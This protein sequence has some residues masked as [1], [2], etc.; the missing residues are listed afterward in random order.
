MGFTTTVFEN[1][2]RYYK[3]ISSFCIQNKLQQFRSF[4]L[5]SWFLNIFHKIKTKFKFFI[6]QIK[7]MNCYVNKN[8][9]KYSY[10]K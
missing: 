6:S 4:M 1:R 5:G 3:K 8:K 7:Q 10:Q 9:K 2:L